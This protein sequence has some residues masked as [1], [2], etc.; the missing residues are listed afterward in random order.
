[1]DFKEAAYLFQWLGPRE[2]CIIFQTEPEVDPEGTS[3]GGEWVD[4]V[5]T[6]LENTLE[7]LGLYQGSQERSLAPPF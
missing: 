5:M 1:M 7:S 2:L 6:A 3:P 4:I